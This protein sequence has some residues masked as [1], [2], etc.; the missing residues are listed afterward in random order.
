MRLANIYDGN[1]N[2][3]KSDLTEIIIYGCMN[4]KLKNVD[5]SGISNNEVNTILKEK[6]ISIKSL[7]GYGNLGLKKKDLKSY[8]ENEKCSVKLKD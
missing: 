1:Y 8:E 3:K 5:I 2:K 6:E 7:P 4:G